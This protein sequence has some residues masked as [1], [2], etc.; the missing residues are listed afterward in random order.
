MKKIYWV[1]SLLILLSMLL[2]ACGGAATTEAPAAVEP[3]VEPTAVPV[4][5]APE[6][7]EAP[8]EPEVVEPEVLDPAFLDETYSAMLASMKAYNT[9]SADALMEELASDNPPFL[10]DVRTTAEVEET[11]HITGA[12]HMPLEQLTQALNMLPG[13]DDPIVVYCGSGWR[14]TIAMTALH[15]MGWNNVRA[16][17]ASFADWVEAGNPVTAG[18]PGPFPANMMA[19]PQP[20]LDTFNAMLAIYGVKPF[21]AVDDEGLNAALGENPDMIVIDVRTAAEVEEKGTIDTGEVELI[22]I[23]LEDLVAQQAMWPADLDAQIAIY[24]GSGHRSTMALT[25]MGSYGYTNLSSLKGGFSGWA[26]AGYPVTGGTMPEASEP[27]ASMLD[28]NFEAMLGSMAGYN[29]VKADALMEELVS[30]TPPFLLDV[31]TAAEVEEQ[32]HIEGAVHISLDQLAQN[33]NSLPDY[34]TP[35]VAYCGSGWR[36]TIAM[37]ALHGLGWENVRALKAAFSDWVAAGYPVADGLPEPSMVENTTDFDPE[38]V[39]TF[40]AMLQV[41][42]VKPFGVVDAETLNTALVD[43]PALIVIDVRTDDELAENGVIDTGE[44]ELIHIPLEQIVAQMDLWPADK[45][46]AIVIYCGSGHRSTM[47]LT[48]LGAYGYS[49]LSSLKGGFGGWAEA[50]YPVA[51]FAT[52]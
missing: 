43:N 41:Y 22:N 44:I 34:G 46:A 10:L 39:A 31:R 29:T 20:L 38:L 30:D 17:K 42:G 4:E 8:A 25:I 18:L 12:A 7:T 16:L 28:T 6:P 24:C 15:G 1:F 51:E 13:P 11:G 49:N 35:I 3:A 45:D 27:E 40:D 52:P 33:L 26:E 19:Y 37:T 50:G 36:A 47:A 32:G 2:S 23:P 14:A 48:I 5:S 21:G 9:I